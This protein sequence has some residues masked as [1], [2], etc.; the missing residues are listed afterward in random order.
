MEKTDMLIDKHIKDENSLVEQ[1]IFTV[2]GFI[3]FNGMNNYSIG[4]CCNS[5]N[6]LRFSTNG[7]PVSFIVRK[8]L[9]QS[10]FNNA[11]DFVKNIQHASG[12]NYII[13]S[14]GRIISLEC[15]ANKVSQC[16]DHRQH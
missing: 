8:V 12:Q 10:N 6:Q 14:P 15:S 1:M 7:L 4:I 3:G 11:I 13:G 16:F 5:L 9:E 2:P